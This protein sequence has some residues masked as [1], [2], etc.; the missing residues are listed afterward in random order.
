MQMRIEHDSIGSRQI[1]VDA[2]YGVQSLRGA[3]K[4]LEIR[5]MHED[6]FNTMH[7]V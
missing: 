5:A 3:E 4:G 1:P 7:H 2:Y 6:I